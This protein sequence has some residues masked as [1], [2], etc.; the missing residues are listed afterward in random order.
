MIY[1]FQMVILQFA[2]LVYQRVNHPLLRVEPFFL[3]GC[4]EMISIG[5]FMFESSCV[6]F[7]SKLLPNS[8][9]HFIYKTSPTFLYQLNHHLH[10]RHL[11]HIHHR[12]Q[13]QSSTSSTSHTSSIHQLR[14]LHQLPSTSHTW[15]IYIHHLHSSSCTGVGT[16]ELHKS[17]WQELL[18]SCYTG[19]SF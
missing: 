7:S 11:H 1:L 19:V 2:M 4:K 12:H 8:T 14:H 15:S 9:F 5:T 10:Q 17:S 16:Q 13:L 6:V 3:G 18:H